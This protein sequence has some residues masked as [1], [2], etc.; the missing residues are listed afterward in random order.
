MQRLIAI[1]PLDPTICLEEMQLKDTDKLNINEQK[2]TYHAK[3]NHKKSGI[4]ISVSDKI[5]FKNRHI[6]TDKGE[7]FH[8]DKRANSSGKHNNNNQLSVYVLNTRAQNS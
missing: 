3:N 7:T 5:D 1:R 4:I 6:T 2:K 8:N